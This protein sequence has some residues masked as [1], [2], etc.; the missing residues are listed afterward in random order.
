MSVRFCWCCEGL[1]PSPRLRTALSTP[2]PPP[3][4]V[5]TA[6]AGS[7]EVNTVSTDTLSFVGRP[8]GEAGRMVPALAVHTPLAL[9]PLS[10]PKGASGTTDEGFVLLSLRACLP[11]R[12]MDTSLTL[13]TGGPPRAEVRSHK[14]VR[15]IVRARARVRCEAAHTAGGGGCH[16]TGQAAVEEQ[17]PLCGAGGPAAPHLRF[18]VD[19]TVAYPACLNVASEDL[20]ESAM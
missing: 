20:I 1:P 12:A 10:R 14:T 8:N 6:P 11:Q 18:C 16:G 5:H 9:H 3:P 13:G 7:V 17:D 19:A 15:P 2:P 4:R